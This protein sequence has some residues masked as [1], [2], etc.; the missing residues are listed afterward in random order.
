MPKNVINLGLDVDGVLLDYV[1]GFFSYLPSIGVIPACKPHEV[2]NFDFK[3][4]FPN[5]ERPDIKKLITDFSVTEGFG[6]LPAYPGAVEAVNRIK[7]HFG[8][9][10]RIV[11]ITSAGTSEETLR[12]RKQNLEL[13]PFDEVNVLPLA[14]DKTEQ[15]AK[16]G[17]NSVFVD[18]LLSNVRAAQNVGVRGV[19]YRQLYNAMDHHDLTMEGWDDEGFDTVFNALVKTSDLKIAS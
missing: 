7:T 9:S 11:A 15:L 18:D 13:F 8:D 1:T 2:D 6:R 12:L 3:C 16:L 17:P 14:G 4:A 5:L 10:L 19:L